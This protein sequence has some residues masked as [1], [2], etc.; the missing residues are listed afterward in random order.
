MVVDDNEEML[1]FFS[2]FAAQLAGVNTVCFNSPHTAL[3][4][5]A[6]AP[7]SF[8]FV[9]TDLQMPGLD[10]IQL[11]KRL[12]AIA[13]ALKVLLVTGNR[14]LT[15]AEARAQGFCGLINKPFPL[16]TIQRTLTRTGVLMPA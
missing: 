7:E 1:A 9:I 12:L 15:E 6:A 11:C 13:P 8:Q 3:A 2:A 16:A 4:A 5:F 14:I 10:G